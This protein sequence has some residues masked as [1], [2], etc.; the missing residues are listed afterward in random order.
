M[1]NSE[2]IMAAFYARREAQ[3]R[4]KERRNQLIMLFIAALIVAGNVVL[5]FNY[6]S[7]V[8]WF[9]ERFGE[10]TITVERPPE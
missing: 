3:I 10:Y 4:R 5:V 7:V 9:R 1:T 6:E 2:E 8:G